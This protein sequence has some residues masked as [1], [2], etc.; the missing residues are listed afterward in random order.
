M[1]RRQS[2]EDRLYKV[3]EAQQGLFTTMQAKA[4]GYAV[5]TPMKTLLDIA[6]MPATPPD[7][8]QQAM[9][10]ALRRGLIRQ[11][12][13]RSLSGESGKRLCRAAGKKGS[14]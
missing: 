5:T 10:D 14:S 11:A 4:C 9:A 6:A 13:L 2:P 7:L 12:E 1:M 8:L 3:A